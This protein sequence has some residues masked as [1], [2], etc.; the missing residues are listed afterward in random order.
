MRAITNSFA[1]FRVYSSCHITI[2][3][4]FCSYLYSCSDKLK[5]AL[6][7]LNA[8]DIGISLSL[9]LSPFLININLPIVHFLR[10][11]GNH[12]PS[13]NVMYQLIFDKTKHIQKEKQLLFS[14]ANMVCYSFI[15]QHRSNTIC[16]MLLFHF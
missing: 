6:F 2:S 1:L 11:I 9:S 12:S 5:Q 16:N 13:E 14:E 15:L 7:G 10:I 4:F 3:N 8:L